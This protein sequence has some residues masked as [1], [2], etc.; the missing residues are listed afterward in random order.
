MYPAIHCDST[1]SAR[2]IARCALLCVLTL[3]LFACGAKPKSETGGE[4]AKGYSPIEEAYYNKVKDEVVAKVGGQDI[5]REALVIYNQRANALPIASSDIVKGSKDSLKPLVEDLAITE[6]AA[7]HSDEMPEGRTTQVLSTVQKYKDQMLI[8]LLLTKEVKDKIKS[9]SESEIKSYYE[10]NSSAYVTPF[11]FS[12]RHIFVANYVPVETRSGDTLESIA[13]RIGGDPKLAGM[14]LVDT[15]DKPLRAPEYSKGT[16]FIPTLQPGERLLVPMGTEG[17]KK[18]FDRIRKAEQRLKAGEDFAKV[19][20]E[21][22]ETATKGEEITGVGLSGRPLLPELLK[23]AKETPVKGVSSIFET[24][25]GYNII[26]VTAKVDAAPKPLEEVRKEIETAVKREKEK[27]AITKYIEQLFTI[28]ALKVNYTLLKDP[29]TPDDAIVA[30]LGKKKFT[31][32]EAQVLVFGK[33]S[34]N[35]SDAAVIDT[36]RANRNVQAN[37]LVYKATELGLDKSSTY[38][39]LVDGQINVYKRKSL[40]EFLRQEEAKKQPSNEEAKAY[41]EANKASFTV[42]PTYTY[43][44]LI[45]RVPDATSTLTAQD[46]SRQTLMKAAELTKDVKTL[47]DFKEVAGKYTVES[48]SKKRN[49]LF[50]DIRE[51]QMGKDLVKELQSLAPG[52]MGRPLQMGNGVGIVWLVE[53]KEGHPATLDDFKDKLPDEVKKVKMSRLDEDLKAKW[54]QEANL[55]MQ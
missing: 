11:N 52:Q 37:L 31:N 27:E 19:A 47:S 23:A 6:I 16:S 14:I 50:Q 48:E 26:Q 49:G 40:V 46:A 32:K 38:R 15:Q 1:R 44:A 34:K 41:F 20:N 21:M 22:S 18:N 43:Y 5:T 13:Q 45:I 17:K 12:M 3:A 8:E 9:P 53:K 55:V 36:L 24:K 2:T 35:M 10:K 54:L 30:E 28:P 33:P 42:P 39:G 4:K 29:A 7:K 25:H 51:D